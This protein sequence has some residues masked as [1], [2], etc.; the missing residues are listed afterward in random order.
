MKVTQILN[1]MREKFTSSWIHK[2]LHKARNWNPLL[3]KFGPY[4]GVLLAAID[5]FLFRGKLPFTLRAIEPDHACLKEADKM[6]KP[7]Y[8]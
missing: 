4:L 2:E 7:P 6:P 8:P 5:Q 3:H 1:L